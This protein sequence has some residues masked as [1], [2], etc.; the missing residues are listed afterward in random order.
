MKTKEIRLDRLVRGPERAAEIE[1]ACKADRRA[2]SFQTFGRN[3]ARNYGRSNAEAGRATFSEY[4][5][6]GHRWHG[7]DRQQTR[8]GGPLASRHVILCIPVS[9]RI[10][11]RSHCTTL[12]LYTRNQL[13]LATVSQVRASSGS[14]LGILVGVTESQELQTVLENLA[15]LNADSEA[16]Y[17]TQGG[18]YDRNR[19]IHQPNIGRRP[20]RLH[21]NS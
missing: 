13:I 20:C 10:T 21:R 7:P 16:L 8:M 19:S 2:R 3:S 11:T 14:P 1:A 18:R 4:F 15:A 6:A 12:P 17:V 5:L 9:I